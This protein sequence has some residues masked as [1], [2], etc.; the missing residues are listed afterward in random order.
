M[1]LQ[2]QNKRYKS[3]YTLQEGKSCRDPSIFWNAAS[4]FTWAKLYGM[5]FGWFCSTVGTAS[6]TSPLIMALLLAVATR[7]FMPL[8]LHSQI[9]KM[10]N[11]VLFLCDLQ[12]DC[13]TRFRFTIPKG[14]CEH[15]LGI[16]N[17]RSSRLQSYKFDCSVGVLVDYRSWRPRQT[18]RLAVS[19]M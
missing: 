5:H 11:S 10:L 17:L 14:C 7:N 19:Y 1:T 18:I 6:L 13:L 15:P 8:S 4:N 16:V 12:T 2:I 3:L 9:F